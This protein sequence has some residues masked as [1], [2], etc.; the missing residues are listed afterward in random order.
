MQASNGRAVPAPVDPPPGLCYGEIFNVFLRILKVFRRD[1][2]CTPMDR[3][4][5]A[6]GEL[7]I[8][9]IPTFLLVIALYFYLKKIYF[10]P[11]ARTLKQ[12][13]D[14][15]EGARSLAEASF[16]RAAEK[17]AEYEAALRSA[18]SEIY[19]EQEQYRHQ[20][21]QEQAQ[22]IQE[23]RRSGAAMVKDATEQLSRELDAAKSDLRV[24]SESLAEQITEAIL[25]RRPV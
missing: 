9:A 17:T 24:Q 20:L 19:R 13:H 16:A 5:A 22:A 12:R 10:D 11:M 21:R 1:S 23:A 15:T 6:L 4:L 8:K 18:R 3:T 2:Y 25:R 14:A 7:L